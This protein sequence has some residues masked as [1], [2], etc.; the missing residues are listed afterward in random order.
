[1]QFG[2]HA[3]KSHPVRIIADVFIRHNERSG[4]TAKGTIYI[5][6]LFC[7]NLIACNRKRFLLHQ[8][9]CI[10]PVHEFQVFFVGIIDICQFYLAALICLKDIVGIRGKNTIRIQQCF[11]QSGIA[12]AVRGEQKRYLII[13]IPVA[14]ASCSLNATS[15]S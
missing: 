15:T 4:T 6:L 8:A 2:R 7:G 13:R 12:P 10:Q 3:G 9:F 1:M 11:F 14:L 5:T